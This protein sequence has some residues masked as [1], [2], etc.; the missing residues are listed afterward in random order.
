MSLPPVITASA[1]ALLGLGVLAGRL[2]VEHLAGLNNDQREAWARRL[3]RQLLPPSFDYAPPR[4]PDPTPDGLL[5]IETFG[6]EQRE[7][8]RAVNGFL[9]ARAR[10]E[11]ARFTTPIPREW[12]REHSPVLAEE[13]DPDNF[14][15]ERHRATLKNTLARPDQRAAAE[16]ALAALDAPPEPE[17]IGE[18]PD[19]APGAR[20]S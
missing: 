17:L 4:P 2:E 19:G 11:V 5:D 15:R 14:V 9:I 7:Y 16:A 8:A 20:S 18:L 13:T 1:D 12:L 10:G 6:G 3:A